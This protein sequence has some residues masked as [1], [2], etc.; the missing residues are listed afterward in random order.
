MQQCN[1][2]QAA[3]SQQVVATHISRMRGL[4]KMV[5]CSMCTIAQHKAQQ[6]QQRQHIWL[7]VV[8]RPSL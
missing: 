2:A 3:K 8:I 6:Q 4:S 5:D 7:A 1:T